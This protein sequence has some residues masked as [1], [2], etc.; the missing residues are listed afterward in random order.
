MKTRS[1]K[2]PRKHLG[3]L[4]SFIEEQ[5]G[6]DRLDMQELA[7]R[8]NVGYRNVSHMLMKDDIQLK[9]AE[10]IVRLYG[11]ELHLYYPMKEY[12]P[13]YPRPKP[14]Y[15]TEGMGNL[16]GLIQYINDTNKTIFTICRDIPSMNEGVM[17]RAI[18]NKNIFLSEL[19]KILD[20]LG[21][22]VI[23]RFQ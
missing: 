17:Y 13:D 5:Q 14:H 3:P 20:H 18:K 2:W 16:T 22:D 8:L 21:I 10:E 11:K 19:Q 4:I 6:T 7:T 23:W 12:P 1:V 9:K 15:N